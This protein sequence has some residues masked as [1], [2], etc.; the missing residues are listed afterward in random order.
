M[1]V[2][3]SIPDHGIC[4]LAILVPLIVTCDHD[5]WPGS[6]HFTFVE[7]HKLIQNCQD[8]ISS[9]K[10][11]TGLHKENIIMLVGSKKKKK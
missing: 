11:D 8:S 4:P 2:N 3:D 1:S 9:V 7:T 10:L 5:S 6:V